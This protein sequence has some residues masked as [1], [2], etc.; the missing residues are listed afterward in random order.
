MITEQEAKMKAAKLFRN[1]M[2]GEDATGRYYLKS[3]N[4]AYNTAKKFYLGYDTPAGVGPGALTKDELVL[5]GVYAIKDN[6]YGYDRFRGR[7]IF[8]IWNEAG[9]IVAFGGR[10]LG[11]GDFPKYINSKESDLYKKGETL[12]ALNFA[13]TSNRDSFI[14]CEGNIDVI[15]LHQ[16][17]YDNAVAACGTSVTDKHI[18]M[19]AKYGKKIYVAT[20]S[21]EAGE[22][23]A[24]K[25]LKKLLLAKIPCAR[26][27]FAPY[28]DVDEAINN[29][30][31]IGRIVEGA[32][33]AYHFI[34]RVSG[35]ETETLKWL[36]N[37]KMSNLDICRKGAEHNGG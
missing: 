21:D 4:I 17:G 10:W 32:E 36:L 33:D 11:D 16:K 23:A 37:V 9:D 19:L 34:Y 30:A 8:P 6:G 20:D 22:K 5:A 31:D 25:I 13:K 26:L 3:R 1:G 35:R 7:L 27:N 29:N 12:Y 2:F 14:L 28:K 18:E 24:V 15:S